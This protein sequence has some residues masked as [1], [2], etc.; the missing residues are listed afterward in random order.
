[1]MNKPKKFSLFRFPYF[2]LT[3]AVLFWSGNFIVGRA[4]R[5]NIPPVTL[6]FWRWCGASL[7]VLFFAWPHLKQNWRMIR[8]HW[9]ILVLLSVLGVAAFNTL[10]YTG[11]QSTIALN[12]FLLQAMMPVLIVGMSFL[13]FRE[14]LS[15]LQTFGIFLSLAGAVVVI[16]QGNV[17]ALFALSLNRGDLFIFIAVVCY[18]GYSVL[19]RKRPSI[20][21]LSFLGFT[22]M[23]GAL[24]LLPFYL[25]EA[26]TLLP[27]P[28]ES[29][30]LW[31]IV[32]VAIF[33]SIVSYFCFNSGVERI[34]ANRA[35]LF[36]YLMPLFGSL[37]AILF[38]G[39]SLHWFHGA[40]IVLIASGILLAVGPNYLFGKPRLPKKE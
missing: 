5:G 23:A 26:Y 17:Q 39:E 1:M 15:L 38:L 27:T 34:G 29:S 33:P 36:M 18:G 6:A 8:G 28:F 24:I 3:L 30:T 21:P 7:L 25:I 2:L 20:H 14:T 16:I 12:A 31:A 10:V 19:L 11:L 9:P 4:I 22:F 35:G 13:L 37:M 32:Y 40:G